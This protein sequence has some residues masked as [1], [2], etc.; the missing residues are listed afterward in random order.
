[1]RK[2]GGELGGPRVTLELELGKARLPGPLV[3]LTLRALEEGH[4]GDVVVLAGLASVPVDAGVAGG[5]EE[6][7]I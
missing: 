6:L 3:G 2:G 5:V 7:G 4:H 1:M